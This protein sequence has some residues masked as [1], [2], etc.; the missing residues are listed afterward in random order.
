MA[1]LATRLAA[2]P[3]IADRARQTKA[4]LH[5]NAGTTFAD[6]LAAEARA[7]TVNLATEGPAAHRAFLDKVEPEFPGTWRPHRDP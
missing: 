1:D 2:G 5:E 3:R 6:A 7:Q 4:L